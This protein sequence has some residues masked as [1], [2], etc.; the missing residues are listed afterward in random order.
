MSV[1]FLGCSFPFVAQHSHP[2]PLLL[3]SRG[4]RKRSGVGEAAL[5]VSLRYLV[6]ELNGRLLKSHVFRCC[7]SQPGVKRDYQQFF[8]KRDV[9]ILLYNKL[10]GGVGDI[11][12]R[13]F[14]HIIELCTAE[15]R[16]RPLFRKE[17]RETVEL[18]YDELLVK[19]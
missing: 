1:V 6:Q 2:P 14:V 17:I 7:F 19:D 10:G 3:L 8:C 13:S 15:L 5:F 11:T 16:L 4:N 12:G 18:L 9:E